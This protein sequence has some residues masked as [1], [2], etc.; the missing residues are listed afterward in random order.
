MVPI[1]L[2]CPHCLQHFFF[3]HLHL[4]YIITNA[5]DVA[6]TLPGRDDLVATRL[7]GHDTAA[8]SSMTTVQDGVSAFFTVTGKQLFDTICFSI[9]VKYYEFLHTYILKGITK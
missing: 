3:E 9:A 6:G 5:H 2:T 8:S 4:Y 7:V 1:I